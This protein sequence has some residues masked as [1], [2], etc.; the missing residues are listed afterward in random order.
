MNQA[1]SSVASN[2]GMLR[3][4]YF[5]HA[6]AFPKPFL[7]L[8]GLLVLSL[9]GVFWSRWFWLLTIVAVVLVWLYWRAKRFQFMAGCVNPGRI[10]SV[11]P[12]RIAVYTDLSTGASRAYPVIKVLEHPLLKMSSGFPRVGQNVSTIAVYRGAQEDCA[13]RFDFEPVV[14]D[15]VTGNQSEIQRV[16]SSIP[17]DEWQQLDVGLSLLPANPSPGIYP[18]P[19]DNLKKQIKHSADRIREI[20]W[21]R[22][23]QNSLKEVHADV[24]ALPS[25][26][27]AHIEKHFGQLICGNLVLCAF[28]QPM[29]PKPEFYLITT[30]G[31]AYCNNKTS[32]EHLPW[33][34]IRE[35]FLT[36]K[37]FSLVMFPEFQVRLLPQSASF[38]MKTWVELE[39]MINAIV[40]C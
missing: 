39:A 28:V 31:L 1:S 34:Q 23:Q 7:I 25:D 27:F 40:Q 36:S 16:F 17:H 5:R 15:I 11:N 19:V 2:P 13:H 6:R 9:L 20:V 37:R 4:N 32:A 24:K 12:P 35:A 18:M 30:V 29:S 21:Q 3:I 22:L 8:H 38:W 10:V 14:T 33:E 26:Q